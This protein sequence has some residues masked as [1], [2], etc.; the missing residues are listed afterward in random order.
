VSFHVAW[1]RG[2]VGRRAN[3]RLPRYRFGQVWPFWP[4]SDGLQ[5][6]LAEHASGS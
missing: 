5:F 6:N 3:L 1:Q 4:D 2:T